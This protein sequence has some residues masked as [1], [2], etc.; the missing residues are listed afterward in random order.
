MLLLTGCAPLPF[1]AYAPDARDGTVVYSTATF[2]RHIPVAVTVDL[3]G[4]T[5]LVS[6]VRRDGREYLGVRFDIPPSQ[7]LIL[8]DG[9]VSLELVDHQKTISATFSGVSLVD[10]PILNGTF[11]GS[12]T[13][14]GLLPIDTP[15]VGERLSSGSLSWNKHFWLATPVET[16]SAADILI[17]LPRM[18]L[19]GV[20]TQLPPLRF[21]RQLFLGAAVINS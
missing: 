2:N 17:T 16:E 4:V 1:H 3:G 13:A 19:N 15:L 7:T 10:S 20:P 11:S 21:H 5:A 9:R 18:S 14:P 8:A 6:L 12:P